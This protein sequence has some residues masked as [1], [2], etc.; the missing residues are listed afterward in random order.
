MKF[1][2]D[3][4][5]SE[6]NQLKHGIDFE[7]AQQLWE[8]SD[9]I[10]ISAKNIDEPRTMFLGKIGSKHWSAI[11]TFRRDTLRIISVRRSRKN[12]IELY[13]S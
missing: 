11:C 10:E 2:Y 9:L 8:D 5:K 3:F 1:E 6:A 13:E 4:R 7:K 12:E